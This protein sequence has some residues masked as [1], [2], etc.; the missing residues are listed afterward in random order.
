[1]NQQERQNMI[2]FVHG[3]FVGIPETFGYAKLDASIRGFL[4]NMGMPNP[5]FS[6]E[7]V[8]F[9]ENILVPIQNKFNKVILKT[10]QKIPKDEKVLHK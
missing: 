5:I 9:I 4:I 3:Y 8:K 10:S 2:S 6:D 7:D 1:M